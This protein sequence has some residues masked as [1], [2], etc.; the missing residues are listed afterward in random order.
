MLKDK[1]NKKLIKKRKK[2]ELT[3]LTH[4]NSSTGHKTEIIL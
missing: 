3:K 2:H 4:Q 1:I